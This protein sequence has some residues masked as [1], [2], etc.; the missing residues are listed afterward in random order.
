[1]HG[2]LYSKNELGMNPFL[3]SALDDVVFASKRVSFDNGPPIDR[4]GRPADWPS[5]N[6]DGLGY[7]ENVEIELLLICTL[8]TRSTHPIAVR[9][10][11]CRAMNCS[12]SPMRPSSSWSMP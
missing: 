9:Q 12:A 10:T 4:P 3:L 11:P 5:Y 6:T 7:L 8:V 1:M 2:P